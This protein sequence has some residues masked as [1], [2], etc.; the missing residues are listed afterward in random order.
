[1]VSI[2]GAPEDQPQ[3]GKS[4]VKVP[5]PTERGQ[6]EVGRRVEAAVRGVTDRGRR[7]LRVDEDRLSEVARRR[8]QR[9]GSH[10][11]RASA[12]RRCQAAWPWT[13]ES[14][15]HSGASVRVKTLTAT[16]AANVT[17]D[18]AGG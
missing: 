6:G 4:G 1:R 11:A 12:V 2:E 9:R 16:A 17:T 13:S 18:D 5:S 15:S 3:R 7:Q 14:G 10:R 8:C